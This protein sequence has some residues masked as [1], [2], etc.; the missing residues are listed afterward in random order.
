MDAQ[1]ALITNIFNNATLIE[2]PF[3]QRPYVWGDDL[4][5]KFIE[6]MEFVVKT[7]KTHFLGAIILKDAGQ[8]KPGA[9]YAQHRTIVD[10]QQRLTTYLLFMKVLCLKLNQPAVFDLQFRIMGGEIALQHGKN[11]SAAFNTCM[12]ASTLTKIPNP[13]PSSKIIE[14]FNYFIDHIDESKL[15]I[16]TIFMNAQ[17][18]RIDLSYDEDEQQIFDTINSLGVRLTTA[19]LLKNYFY[20]RQDIDQY[21]KGWVEV[22]EK[23]NEARSYWS[24]E[25]E[26]GR[27][28]RSL[29]DVFFDS[30]FQLFI[31]DPKYKVSTEDKISYS[32]LEHLAKS[33]QDFI[34]NYCGGDKQVILAQ[35]AEYANKFR[36]IF[37][38]ECINRHM[39]KQ[40]GIDRV[41]VIIFGL[42]N[43][44]MIPYVLYLA[45]NVQDQEEFNKMMGLLESYIMRRMVIRATTKNYNNLF[46]SLILN[47]IKTTESLLDALKRM[48]DGTTYVPS[49]EELLSGFRNS[50]LS[51]LQAKGV[52]YYI[53]S[54]MRP[55]KSAVALLGFRQYSLEHL[56]PRKWRNHWSPCATED[57]AKYRDQKLQTLGNFAIITQA[58]NTSISDS[59]WTSKKKGKKDNPGLDQCAAG[60]LTMENVLPES[61]WDESKI[62]NRA[63][64]LY[65]KAKQLWSDISPAISDGSVSARGTTQSSDTAE[66]RKRFWIY[67]LPIIKEANNKTGTYLNNN[68]VKV[69]EIWGS[70]GLGR[71]SIGCVANY[72]KAYV[73]FNIGRKDKEANKKLFDKL[74]FHKDE[75]NRKVGAELKWTRAEGFIASWIT[76]TLDGVSIGNENDWPGMAEFLAKWSSRISEAIIPYLLD[77]N[78]T[79]AKLIKYSYLTREWASNNTGISYDIENCSRS[80]TRFTTDTMTEILPEI[81]DAPS[82]WG[83]DS[84]YFYE[85]CSMS[86]G[87]VQVQLS[88]NSKNITDEFRATC[89][90]IQKYFPSKVNNPN[91]DYR[92]PFKTKPISIEGLSKEALFNYLDKCLE[93][94]KAFENDLKVKLGR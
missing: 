85:I 27:S 74:Y 57:L 76:Y 31:Q 65:E 40:H 59:D 55:D 10:G 19:E 36:A 35:M 60:L 81:K 54:G 23:D 66:L 69:N 78:S 72:D 67:A 1:K 87:K 8:P 15:D 24:Q 32:R 42:K 34:K 29:I 84:H 79:E 39:P 30:Y 50:K 73:W 75:I 77:E 90:E 53:E 80:Y 64:W 26:M 62:E 25:F 38:P 14:A 56:M 18:V 83:S 88:I 2:V 89:D 20:S 12:S 82:S 70:F 22:F 68:P 46:V 91:W 61:S 94:I 16:M 28:T 49:D 13:D 86:S 71:C 4:W 51:N 21:N 7:K 3:F 11:D 45:C 48:G 6:D 92:L 9:N 52:I 43:A 47:Q 44:T 93:E 17:F 5:A 41:N 58:L 63:Q 33:Y 37:D